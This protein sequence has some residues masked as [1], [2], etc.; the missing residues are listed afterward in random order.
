MDLRREQPAHPGLQRHAHERNLAVR[1]HLRCCRAPHS[2]GDLSGSVDS[3]T[4]NARSELTSA[5]RTKNGQP[6]PGFSE[7]FDYDPIGNRRSSSTYNEKGEAQTSTYQANNLNQYT[8]RTTPG[9]AAVRDLT[10]GGNTIAGQT[11]SYFMPLIAVAL[12][13]L[14][15]VMFFTYLVGKL[16]RRLRT[17]ER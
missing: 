15:L 2:H 11:Y 3:Y 1:L 9:Y 17:S 4:Y 12:I 6:I 10:Y 7:D 13:Y 14:A 5:R 8:S 16:E